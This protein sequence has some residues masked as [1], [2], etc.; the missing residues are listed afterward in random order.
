MKILYFLLLPVVLLAQQIPF[1]QDTI[2]YN[3]RF[4]NR[5]YAAFDLSGKIQIAYSGQIGTN[6]TTCEIYYAKENN[7]GSFT[8]INITNNSYNENYPTLS[9][10]QN[11]KTHIGFVARDDVNYQVK[12]VNNVSGTFTNPIYIT[13]GGLNKAVPF[14]KIGPD[15][16]MHFVYFT[17]E[18]G[19]D[20][21]YYRSFR[22]KDSLL[23]PEITLAPGEMVGDFD[24]TLDVD[25]SGFVHIV[26]KSSGL[27]YFTNISGTFT[28]VPTSVTGNIS[29][30]RIKFDKQQNPVIVYRSSDSK[31]YITKKSGSS[32]TTPLA[33]TPAGQLPSGQV[34]IAIDDSNYVY[35]TYQSSQAAS[36]KGFYLIYGKDDTFSDTLNL[37]APT[38]GYVTRNSS[39]TIAKGKGDIAIFYSPGGMRNG[40]AACDI[41]MKRGNI[42]NPTPVELK[43][44]TALVQGN[45]VILN[46]STS[47]EKNNYGFDVERKA[48]NGNWNKAAF[49]NGNGTSVSENYYSFSDAVPGKGKYSYRLKQLDFDG[50]FEYSN[51]IEVETGVPGSF[52]LAQNYPNPFNPS[53]VIDYSL[54]YASNMELSLYDILGNKIAV[55]VNE[56]KPAGNYTY[57]FDA[58]KLNLSSG[59]Y[60]Y[61]MKAGEFIQS[62]KLTFIK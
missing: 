21:V 10:D 36:G 24:A 1:P 44:F 18:V 46:W 20:Y 3:D 4:N 62:R 23:S 16:V 34:H 14:S 51:T 11:N 26:L 54:P 49:I 25:A 2:A 43:S 58:G 22:L 60:I 53:T 37:G 12:Y 9:I 7:D 47:T 55:L 6:S 52:S 28:E 27:K 30:P 8:T 5:Q 19:Q 31:L 61:E 41:F 38:E 57:Q 35:L 39:Q 59:V 40:Q 15:S 50:S 29:Y 17:N 42:F 45:N 13:T 33:L 56:N 32:F 48:V